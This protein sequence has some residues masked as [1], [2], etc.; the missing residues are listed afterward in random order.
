[1]KFF[2]VKVISKKEINHGHEKKEKV[3]WLQRLRW[4]WS[5]FKYKYLR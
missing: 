3:P 1:M 2:R 4:W 5:D